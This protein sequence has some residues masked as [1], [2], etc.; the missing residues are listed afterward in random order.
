[1]AS[2]PAYAATVDVGHGIAPSTLDTSLTAPTHTTILV[3][4]TTNGT[5]IEEIRTVGVLTT[6]AS[7]INIFHKAS[8]VYYL[9][10]QILVTAVTSSTTALAYKDVRTYNNLILKNGDTL[11]VAVTVSGVQ[12]GFAFNVYGAD[13]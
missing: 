6:V 10:D 7:V 8:S 2:A 4:G 1:M 13:F 12:S 9:V 11:E 3:T 5:K